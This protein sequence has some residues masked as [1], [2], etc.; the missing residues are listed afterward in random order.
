MNG[1]H[2]VQGTMPLARQRIVTDVS[3]GFSDAN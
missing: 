3:S 2:P 1:R